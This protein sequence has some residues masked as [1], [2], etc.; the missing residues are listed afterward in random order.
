[1]RKYQGM[2]IAAMIVVLG[3]AMTVESGA[4]Q[5]SAGTAAVVVGFAGVI[6]ALAKLDAFD[7]LED[8]LLAEIGLYIRQG[9]VSVDLVDAFRR[10]LQKQPQAAT[11]GIRGEAVS[12]TAFRTT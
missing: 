2:L 4:L 5:L 12:P 6:L 8:S 11:E 10:H 9:A 7:F 3:A 1:M